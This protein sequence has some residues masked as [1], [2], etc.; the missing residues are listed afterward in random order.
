MN[1]RLAAHAPELT[2][3]YLTE[4]LT[5][6]KHTSEYQRISSVQYLIPWVKNLAFFANPLSD[7]FDQ[8]GSRIRD[9]LRLLIDFTAEHV[10]VCYSSI[11]PRR[12]SPLSL[13]LAIDPEVPVVRGC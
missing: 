10:N 6:A 3:D 4:V 13:D 9:V 1:D 7:H 2:L 5:A 12:C 8:S 11:G